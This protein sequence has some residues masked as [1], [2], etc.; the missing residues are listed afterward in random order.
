MDQYIIQECKT[1]LNY[2]VGNSHHLVLEN[3]YRDLLDCE[4]DTTPDWPYIFQKVYLHA[5]LK[6]RRDAATW[7]QNVLFQ[8]MDPIQQIALRQIFPYGRTLLARAMRY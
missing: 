8:T 4:F 1:I 7:M 3:Y 6:G 2:D 5:C